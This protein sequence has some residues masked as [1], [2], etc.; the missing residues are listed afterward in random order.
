MSDTPEKKQ[1]DGEPASLHI[2]LVEDNP[3]DVRLILEALHDTD[4][5]RL[6]LQHAASLGE[7]EAR[8]AKRQPDAILL[9]LSLP[10]SDGLQSV[11]RARA[12]APNVP[13]VVLSGLSDR[14][15]ALQAVGAGAQDYL[16]K[17]DTD[18]GEFVTRAVLYA[19]ERQRM[20][21][22]LR[23]LSLRDA[24]TGLHN[25]RGFLEM[26]AHVALL[27]RRKS[28]DF[29]VGLADL[30]GLKAI[31]DRWGHAAGD[32]AI[33]GA[34]EILRRTF[35]ESDVLARLGGDEFGIIAVDAGIKTAPRLIER[36]Q[37]HTSEW[38]AASG[39]DLKVSLTL[40]MTLA[41]AKESLDPNRLLEAADR[42]LYARKGARTKRKPS[43]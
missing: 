22:E 16:I 12:A 19:I 33:A 10:D 43:A 28:A 3:G 27:A 25:R 8:I 15:L 23:D 29:I 26:F 40:G 36:L 5:V 7:A 6:D 21:G 35:R 39:L 11:A 34:A 30:D 32:K 41:G 14:E 37:E 42:D 20:M 38:N 1:T 2:L 17:G 13:I 31:N 18:L 4:A 24:L 9:D